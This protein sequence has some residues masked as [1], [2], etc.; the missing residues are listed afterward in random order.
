MAS[1]SNTSNVM[2][3]GQIAYI[4]KTGS[5]TNHGVIEINDTSVVHNYSEGYVAPTS[6]V[7]GTDLADTTEYTQCETD[8]ENY[9]GEHWVEN[10]NERTI[11]TNSNVIKTMLATGETNMRTLKNSISDGGELEYI[12]STGTQYIATSYYPNGN[13]KYEISYTNS[14][15][16]GIVFGAYNNTWTNGSGYYTNVGSNAMSYRHYNSNDNTYVRSS[17]RELVVMDKGSL[18]INGTQCLNTT[19]KT[20][21]I[22]RPL[23][24]FAGNMGGNV[25]QPVKMRLQYFKI[26]EGDTLLLHLVPFEDVNGTACLH[27]KVNNIFYYNAGTGAFIPGPKIVAL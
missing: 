22:D 1:E 9:L 2:V 19:T 4:R 26:Y 17:A 27:D 15:V 21:T 3:N 23:F 20:F 10:P 7:H 12:E 14:S 16:N 5:M 11:I 13:T 18:T 8:M 25:E 24:I 6:V